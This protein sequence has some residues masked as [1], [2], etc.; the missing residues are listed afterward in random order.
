MTDLTQRLPG[1]S[2]W[3]PFPLLCPG[4]TCRADAN[5]RPL[6]FD[7]DHPSAYANVMLYPYFKTY[8]GEVANGR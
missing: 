1:I 5:G 6:F 7:G 4:T 3:D 8:M 2:V